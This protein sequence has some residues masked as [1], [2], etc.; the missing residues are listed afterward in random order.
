MLYL[1]ILEKF[2]NEVSEEK[3]L[4]RMPYMDLQELDALKKVIEN[5]KAMESELVKYRE[6]FGSLK[7]IL[8]DY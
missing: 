2:I 5:Y 6:V 7:E 8:V 1:E 4:D 3:L